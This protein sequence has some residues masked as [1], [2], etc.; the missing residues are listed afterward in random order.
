MAT[1]LEATTAI[2]DKMFSTMQIGQK[3][4]LDSVKSWAETVETVYAKLPEL[5]TAD[6]I[7]PT[8]LMEL[9]LG[10]SE[11]LMSSQQDFTTKLFEAMIPATRAATAATAAATS[12]PKPKP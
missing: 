11:K 12:A 5:A 3:A 7:K 9:T 1:A 10:F 8:Q 6:P 2:Q 4:M